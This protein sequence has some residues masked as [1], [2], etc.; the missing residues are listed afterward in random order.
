M[1]FEFVITHRPQEDEPI[2]AILRERLREVLVAK[3][4]P[5]TTANSPATNSPP[6]SSTSSMPTRTA[7]SPRRS[8]QR[9]GGKSDDRRFDRRPTLTIARHPP[10]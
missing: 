9:C 5:T 4:T 6:R 7:L 8:W 1:N 10:P 3:A 2:H